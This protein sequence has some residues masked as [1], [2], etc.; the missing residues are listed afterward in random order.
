MV[1]VYKW[2]EYSRKAGD[3]QIV[4]E[5][6][7]NIRKEEGELQPLMVVS[8]A[9]AKRSPLHGY[10]EWD[11]NKAAK[12]HRAQQACQLICEV[13]VRMSDSKSKPVM[14]KAF[15]NYKDEAGYSSY[16]S[17]SHAMN[18]EQIREQILQRAWGEMKS[19]RKKFSDMKELSDVFISMKHFGKQHIKKRKAG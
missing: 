7:E 6:L 1:M 3:A 19:F 17:I 9:K 2:K 16:T 10:F 18:N 12:Q 14:V 13:V 4:G 11:D 5:E 15:V 8:R